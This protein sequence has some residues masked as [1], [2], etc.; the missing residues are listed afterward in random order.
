MVEV[1]YTATWKIN[2]PYCSSHRCLPICL[3]SGLSLLDYQYG[4]K[5]GMEVVDRDL[6]ELSLLSPTSD[7]RDLGKP[8]TLTHVMLVEKR[9]EKI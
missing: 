8:A 6:D 4:S 7:T 9:M 2:P 3:D 5:D 1:R